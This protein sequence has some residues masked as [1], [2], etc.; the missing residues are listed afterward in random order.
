MTEL[1]KTR[2]A[3]VA[4]AKQCILSGMQ[5]ATRAYDDTGEMGDGWLVAED[6]LKDGLTDER[7]RNAMHHSRIAD[8]KGWI[9]HFPQYRLPYDALNPMYAAG[10]DRDCYWPGF[11]R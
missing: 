2:P 1:E 7:F 4:Y 6:M 10:T 9:E 3:R 8:L 5:S 11:G